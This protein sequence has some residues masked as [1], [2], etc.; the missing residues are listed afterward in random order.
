VR[1]FRKP[2]EA[3]LPDGNKGLD[4]K[5]LKMHFFDLKEKFPEIHWKEVWMRLIRNA[6]S[7]YNQ[8]TPGLKKHQMISVEDLVKKETLEE[9]VE[10][11]KKIR[12][13]VDFQ[14]NFP[15]PRMQAETKKPGRSA[16]FA[17]LADKVP[18]VQQG[19]SEA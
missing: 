6:R 13:P 3:V 1:I 8:Q 18:V 16:F 5:R 15:S 17:K 12:E 14:E 7:L 9:L 10:I 11:N 19:A 4:R 2:G